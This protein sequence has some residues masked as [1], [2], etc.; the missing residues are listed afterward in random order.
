MNGAWTAAA[1]RG[2]G[3]GTPG[4]GHATFTSGF[5][6]R[7]RTTMTSIYFR[8]IQINYSCSMILHRPPSFRNIPKK[9][10]MIRG[11]ISFT[12]RRALAGNT[13]TGQ[14][15]DQLGGNEVLIDVFFSA[16]LASYQSYGVHYYVYN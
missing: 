4:A 15:Y 9:E 16:R 11:N 14:A 2:S 8:Y 10:K 3:T 6:T 13:E 12:E 1:A 5:P 7:L